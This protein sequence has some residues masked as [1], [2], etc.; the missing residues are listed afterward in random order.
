MN[1]GVILAGGTGSRMGIVD[2]PKA[3]HRYIWKTNYYS[4][5]RNI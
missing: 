5:T 3:V 4:H 1:I 2:K